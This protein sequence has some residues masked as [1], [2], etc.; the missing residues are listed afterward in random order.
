MYMRLRNSHN[1]D[2][3]NTTAAEDSNHKLPQLTLSG[4]KCNGSKKITTTYSYLDAILRCL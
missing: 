3:L 1:I 4:V 2:R